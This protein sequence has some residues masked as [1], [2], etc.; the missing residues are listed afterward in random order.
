MLAEEAGQPIHDRNAFHT[1][2]PAQAFSCKMLL[3]ILLHYS[4][5][6]GMCQQ[7]QQASRSTTGM[8]FIFQYTLLSFL[9]KSS[10]SLSSTI[11]APVGCVSRGSRPANPRPERFSYFNTRSYLFCAQAPLHSSPQSRLLWDAL[12]EATGQPVHDWMQA[13]TFS[14]GF[15]VVSVDLVDS[16]TPQNA[17]NL[18]LTQRPGAGGDSLLQG[19]P[20]QWWIPVS[21]TSTVRI[22]CKYANM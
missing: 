17:A 3:F 20:P 10:T 7:R 16:G 11:Q 22:I 8:L 1:S 14:E 2:I 5:S 9:C 15:P 19:R 12:A 13:W 6:S 4:G 21:F 18:V